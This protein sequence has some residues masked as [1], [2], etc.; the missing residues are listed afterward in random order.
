[1]FASMRST[2]RLRDNPA[3][4]LWALVSSGL[5]GPAFACELPTLPILPRVDI[6]SELDA[7]LVR[8]TQEYVDGIEAYV[9]CI[10][11]ELESLQTG[12]F[13]TGRQ[14]LVAR[15]NAAVAEAEQVRSLFIDRV[16]PIESLA[17]GTILGLPAS[18]CVPSGEST[19]LSAVNARAIL[20]RVGSD[21]SYINVPLVACAKPRQYL[22]S[23]QILDILTVL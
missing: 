10:R 6:A 12:G 1:M 14:L 22:F 7:R 4:L 11:A 9:E 8:D 13:T 3:T 23:G 5:G 15:N 16:G 19:S 21:E 18:T 2:S 20:V 17:V